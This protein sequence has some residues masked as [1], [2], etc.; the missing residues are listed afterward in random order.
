M[1]EIA[2]ALVADYGVPIVFC[3]TFLS[4]LALPVPSSLLMLASG[5]FAATGDLSLT[6][7]LVAAFAGAVLGD[8]TG[9]WIAR[10]S[11]DRMSD[12]FQRN[13]KRA[14]L[15]NRGQGFMQKWGGSSIFFSCWLVAPLGP[16]I[17]YVSGLTR[18][19]W[20]RFAL[21]GIAGET[22][23]VSLYVGLGYVFADNITAVAS[24]LGNA[25]GFV[26]AFAAVVGLGY[27]LWTASARKKGGTS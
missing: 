4:C 23:W 9:Y 17:N 6:A 3:V 15:R 16:Y 18:F 19:H 21:W 7:V 22:V 10:V 26:T 27:W 13:P 12:W 20:P 8:N 25:S 11:G 14:A 24:L 2:L 1:S 5:G